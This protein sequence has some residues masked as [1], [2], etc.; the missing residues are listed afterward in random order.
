MVSSSSQSMPSTGCINRHRHYELE[1]QMAITISRF[2]DTLKMPA[3]KRVK[4]QE[5]VVDVARVA[6]KI[7]GR[8]T[9]V[10]VDE[11]LVSEIVN[12][13]SY[14]DVQ[15][16]L[17]DDPFMM[18]DSLLR[19]FVQNALTLYLDISVKRV[20]VFS[21]RDR[22]N[23]ILLMKSLELEVK[24]HQSKNKGT[25]LPKC[26]RISLLM[27]SIFGGIAIW[28]HVRRNNFISVEETT[29]IA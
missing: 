29:I 11:E 14:E 26:S 19:S 4:L 25:W 21:V 2:H 22:K 17:D 23:M 7:I 5:M 12:K 24:S 16:Q 6:I 20:H 28:M 9:N 13:L 1:R 15:K 3:I 18:C 10:P 27:T 8:I